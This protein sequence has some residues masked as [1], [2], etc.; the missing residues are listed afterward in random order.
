MSGTHD[1]LTGPLPLDAPT[2]GSS[3]SALLELRALQPTW[4]TDDQGGEVLGTAAPLDGDGVNFR[5]ARVMIQP[6]GERRSAR[7]RSAA[8]ATAR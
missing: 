6:D 8:R 4:A 1:R 5:V 7:D 3:F 2:I